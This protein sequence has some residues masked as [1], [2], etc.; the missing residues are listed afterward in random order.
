MIIKNITADF[1]VAEQL[2]VADVD[3]L[4]AQGVKGLMCNRPDG[5][6]PEQPAYAQIEAAAI[7]NGLQIRHVPVVSGA[8]SDADIAA[9][10]AAFAELPRPLVA[11]CR[12]GSRSAN[13]WAMDQAAQ[14]AAT[15]PVL[16]AGRAAETRARSLSA[17]GPARAERA[18][19]ASNRAN[20]SS[21][22]RPG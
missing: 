8:I 14:G 16:A 5:E 7:R 20:P 9:F 4:A 17:A 10:G 11:F 3:A 6:T 1:A 19:G 2:S 12:S 13:L 18:G 22:P 15:E 21:A